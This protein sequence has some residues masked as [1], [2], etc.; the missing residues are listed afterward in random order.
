MIKKKIQIIKRPPRYSPHPLPNLAHYV[1]IDCSAISRCIIGDY[2]M[3][4]LSDVNVGPISDAEGNLAV[5]LLVFMTFIRVY[6]QYGHVDVT[7]KDS[8]PNEIWR[9]WKLNGFKRNSVPQLG[10]N[11]IYS[12]NAR[13]L[14]WLDERLLYKR[15]YSEHVTKLKSFEALKSFYKNNNLLLVDT[16][17]PDVCEVYNE[18][19]IN[20]RNRTYNHIYALASLLQE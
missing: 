18:N 1:T 6:P 4:E 14:D 13:E 12:W 15:L 2:S 17:L 5:N 7:A 11:W 16:A 3:R 19:M 8:Q 9:R 20:E 10:N